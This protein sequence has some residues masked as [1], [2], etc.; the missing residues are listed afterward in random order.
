MDKIAII[1]LGLIGGSIGL[2]LK[3]QKRTDL[4]VF[5]FDADVGTGNKAVKRNAVDKAV[6]KLPEAVDGAKLIVI[7]TPVFGIREAL[8]NISGLVQPGTVITDTG[9]TKRMVLDWAAEYL[10][11]GVS[12]IGGNPLAGKDQT[13]I[14][15][16]SADLFKNTRYCLIPGKNA[17]E[18]A[19]LSV[20]EMVE[21][22]GALPYFIDAY[23][24][25]SFAAGMTLLPLLT[26]EAMVAAV[27]K[28]P[29]WREMS[30]L[31]ASG[32][33]STS[34]LCATDPLNNLDQLMTNRDLVVHW[35]NEAIRELVQFRDRVNGATNEGG[36]EVLGTALAKGWE[37]RE[38]WHARYITGNTDDGVGEQQKTAS[39]GSAGEIMA[40][41]MLG[42][43]LRERYQKAM[44]PDEKKE[45]ER[46]QRRF[47]RA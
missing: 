21:G 47:R 45:E 15:K 26:S 32:F 28:S 19:I 20:T 11:Q 30:R 25:D 42:T 23:E 36:A 13:G 39:F 17:S 40:D 7:A 18:D 35:T 4:Q 1:G 16:A 6:W 34:A 44:N 37:A 31:A 14:D 8:Q 29:A 10:P 43:K 22:L 38:V 2:A 24:H 46:R 3:K 33:E 5:G 27:S 41:F 12:F 9:G